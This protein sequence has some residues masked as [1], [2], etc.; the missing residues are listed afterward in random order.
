MAMTTIQT[1]T[2][3]RDRL[4]AL[5]PPG[6]KLEDAIVKLIE[7]YEAD[8]TRL[9]LLA[10]KRFADAAADTGSVA[11]ASRISDRLVQLAADREAAR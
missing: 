3:T 2:E 9:K 5:T 11:R 7:T 8:Q 1:S 10:E 6:G 4:A